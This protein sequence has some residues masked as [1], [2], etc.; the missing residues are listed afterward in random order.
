M[1]TDWPVLGDIG[2]WPLSAIPA[3]N[4]PVSGCAMQ[5]K[6]EQK[7]E[8]I[9]QAAAQHFSSQAYH[10]VL[11][12]QIARTAGVGKGT[13]YVYFKDKHDLYSEVHLCG[14][15]RLMAD[16]RQSL[17]S[18]AIH[19]GA[20]ALRQLVGHIVGFAFA[21][22]YLFEMMRQWPAC[23]DDKRGQWEACRQE[24]STLI[25]TIIV[26]GIQTGEFADAH[27]ELTALYIPGFIRSAILFGPKGIKAE[28][29]AHHIASFVLAGLVPPGA[30]AAPNPSLKQKRNR[31]SGPARNS[32]SAK[33]SQTKTEAGHD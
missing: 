19:S 12:S 25:E 4:F 32:R 33:R 29:L 7:R 26:R 8:I 23:Q 5:V 13:I 11:L 21:N 1:K 18:P 16:L 30:S 10:E 15:S 3:P 24:L 9:L 28:T 20:Q 6:N 27:P 14:F 31:K 17:D 2:H 22:R